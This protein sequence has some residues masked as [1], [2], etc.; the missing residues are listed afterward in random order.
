M[1]T[2][3]FKGE[4]PSPKR[5]NKLNQ[6]DFVYCKASGGA[7]DFWGIYNSEVGIITIDGGSNACV[8]GRDLYLG[9]TYVHWTIIKRVPCNK[10]KVSLE[11]IN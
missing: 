8:R 3:K 7:L 9:E 4:L 11:E 1:A 10:M 6:G 5:D 2:V